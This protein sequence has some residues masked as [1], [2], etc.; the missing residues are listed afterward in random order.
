MKYLVATLEDGRIMGYPAQIVAESYANYFN[1]QDDSTTFQ[2]EYDYI[3]NEH[4]ELEDLALNNMDICEDV[5]NWV[6]LDYTPKQMTELI[7][8][9]MDNSRVTVENWETLITK[10][11]TMVYKE[12]GDRYGKRK[13]GHNRNIFSIC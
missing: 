3:I 9:A 8:N 13:N 10:K 11:P 6:Q 1:V 12:I 2:H 5:E 7:K 4:G